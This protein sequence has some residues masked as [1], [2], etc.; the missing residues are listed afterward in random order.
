[1]CEDGRYLKDTH[2]FFKRDSTHFCVIFN[3]HVNVFHGL[4]FR[5][6]T[7]FILIFSCCCHI[8]FVL[9]VYCF[10]FVYLYCFYVLCFY[11]GFIIGAY[12]VKLAR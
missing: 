7:S 8:L 6:S 1:M 3:Q 12:A 5:P 9:S 10:G 4:G 2:Y 11:A